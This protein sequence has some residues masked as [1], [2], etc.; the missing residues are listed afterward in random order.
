METISLSTLAKPLIS[1][2]TALVPVVKQL[3]AE[4]RAGADFANVK[5]ALLDAPLEETL[6]R[7]QDIEAHD[8]WWREL[9]Q[10][11]ESAYVRPDYLAKPSIREWLNEAVVR[12]DLKT[13]ARAS[14]L[15]GTVDQAAIRARLAERYAHYTGE[16]GPLARGPIEAI[17]NIL[18]AGT[19]ARGTKGD[20]LIA[21]LVQESHE[22]MSARFDTIEAKIGELSPDEIVTQ[23]HT[24]KCQ[25]VLDLILRRRSM[26]TVD[27]RAEIAALTGRLESEGDLR[28]CARP[29]Q[30]QIYLWAARLHA[31]TKDKMEVAREYRAKALLI[32]SAA[33]TEIIDAWLS[34]NSGDIDGALARLRNINTP[35]ARSNL[36]IMLSLHHGRQRALEWLD[37]NG[38]VDIKFLT[39][40]GWKNAATLLAEAGRWEDAAARLEALSDEI[41]AECPDLSYVDGVINAAMTLPASIRRF[42]LTM[43]VIERQVETLQG[44]EVTARRQRALHSFEVAKK[45]LG[46]LGEKMRAAGAETWLTW[47]LLTE[48]SSREQGERIVIAAMR[49]GATAVDHAQLAYTFGIP[50]DPAP[51]QRYLAIRELASGLSPPEVAAKLAL[52]RHT[53]SKAEVVSFLEQ[54]RANLSSVVT[55]A[56]YWLLLV[57]ALAEAGQLERAE[58][59][60]IDN[61][62]AFAEDFDRV[63]DQIRLRRG[64][65]VLKSFEDR[66][67]ETD[68]DIDL[69]TLCNNLLNG[70]DL[71]KLRRYSLELFERQRNRRNAHRVCDALVRMDRHRELVDF[72]AAADDLVA[73]DDDLAL[74]KAWSLFHIG[75]LVQAKLINDRLRQARRDPND[76]RLEINLAMAMGTWENFPDIVTREWAE[77][78]KREPRYL[79]H[80]AQLAAD[81]DK[82]RAIELAR[83]ATRKAPDSPEILAAASIL[84]YRL[85]QDDEAMAWMVEAA[86]LSP[87]EHGPV[88]TGGMRDLIDIAIAGAD[89]TRGVQE[90]FSAARIP[91]HTAAP[92][93]KMPMTRLLV[94]Q[95]RDNERERDPR[96]RTVI[97]IRHGVRGILEMSPVRRVAA[98]ITSLLL[99]AELELLPVLEKRFDGIA[100]PWSTMELLLIESQRCR[101]HQP[102]RIA[103]AKKLRELIV[104]NTL[105]PLI[106]S[107]E[108]PSQ[109]VQEVGPDL[110]ELLHTAKQS[111]GRVIRPLPIYRIQTFMEEEANL[112]DYAPLVM[113]TLQ[114]VDVLEDDGVLYRQTIDRARR[115]LA[116]L[117]Q[118][119]PFGTNKPG[120]GPLFLDGLAVAYLAGIG[121]LD[122]LH[123]SAREFQVHPSTVTEIE[124]LIG[125]E[126][127]S[128]RVLDALSELRIWLRDGI[129][130]GRVTVMPRPQSSKEEDMGIE[131]RVLQ[132]MLTDIGTAD[133][134]LIDDRMAGAQGRVTDRSGHMAPIVDTLDLLHD[135]TR[136]GLLSSQDRFHRHHLLRSR[137]FV[138]IPV[139][140]DEI[141]GHL[142]TRKPD[143][144]TGVLRENA[145]LRGIRENLQR[146]R[147]T[148]IVQQPAETPYLDRLR[149]TGFLAIRN[150]WA[151]TSIPIPTAIARTEWL[152]RNLMSTP[153]DWAHTI[154]DPAGVI[155]PTTGFLNEVSGL[156][157]TIPVAN[158]ERARA[159][160]DWIQAVILTPLETG[161]PEVLRDLAGILNAHIRRLAN[162]WTF[163]N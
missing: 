25:G 90:A 132:E 70:Q 106:S 65:D 6:N 31:S 126:A 120:E 159:F 56:G 3:R 98:D 102:S 64:E 104:D 143:P 23:T 45:S 133:A 140:L 135:F 51:L 101:F 10:R 78:D 37:A 71:D 97:P 53:R 94:S 11:A 24:E 96:R 1:I 8:T 149:I 49:E 84:A 112:G 124:Q 42:A 163:K 9:L 109:L 161:S 74:L 129:A 128:Q 41:T 47:L 156:L 73:I 107:A 32:D 35:D 117:E 115:M 18:L 111:D 43:Q 77:R 20:L 57:T 113:T 12:S 58:Q 54:E 123:R 85:G 160:R 16:A 60:L 131:T 148:T 138:C 118:R 153:I 144:S 142:A 81:V 158:L 141:Q 21:G 127:E 7:L 15:P 151:D 116:S 44:A 19:L 93:W 134:V 46:S 29:V 154:V 110:A 68:E 48:P 83:E 89:T 157:L 155:P 152:W 119:E 62:D 39:A 50:F 40:L 92:F 105:C 139:E 125:T 162:E 100:I 136:T 59:T 87:P 147:S 67:L 99:L 4:R 27:A 26:P 122:D 91:L 2:G 137:G 22:Q 114:F 30:A 76:A 69:L 103:G 5:T 108:P 36:L 61:R 13:L 75:S 121:L 38:P 95:A 66:F 86:R 55:P 14:L 80:L 146:L 34:A 17:V 33:D 63:K 82:D 150:I 130:T 145:E 88:M 72:L 52:Y 28:F 79:L